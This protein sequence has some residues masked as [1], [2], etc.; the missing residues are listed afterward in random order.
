MAVI[1]TILMV[2]YDLIFNDNISSFIVN[3]VNSFMLKIF[4]FCTLLFVLVVL[5]CFL[6][7]TSGIQTEL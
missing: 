6:F 7:F 2:T 1:V 3:A 5:F 4:D